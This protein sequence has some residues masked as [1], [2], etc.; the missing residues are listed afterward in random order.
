MPWREIRMSEQKVRLVLR[1]LEEGYSIAEACRIHGISRPTAY[2]WL[3]RYRAKGIR[4]LEEKSRKSLSQHPEA[5]STSLLCE[6]IKIRKEHPHWGGRT[7]RSF[8]RNRKFSKKLPHSRTIDRMLKRAG[9]VIPRAKQNRIELP[10]SRLVHPSDPNMVWTTD[11]KGWWEMLNGEKCY[12][13][14]IR[15]AMS[16]YLISFDALAQQSFELTKAAFIKAFRTYGI[17]L[18]ICSDNGQP[19]ATVQN[20]WGLTQLSVW[21]LKLGITPVRIQPGKPYQ[22]GAHERVHL[23]IAREIEKYPE[24]NLKSEQQR[25]DR[26]K[27]DFN[28]VRPHH[29]LNM[30]TPEDM[31]VASRRRYDE[32]D[33]IYMYPDHFETRS[34]SPAGQF[35]WGDK[36][37]NFSTAFRG[38]SIAIEPVDRSSVRVWFTDFCLGTCD[39]DFNNK[40]TPSKL[41][42]RV[43]IKGL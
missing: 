15:D 10:E 35:C 38:E 32:R 36:T 28:S 7:I 31:Y 29:A 2:K 22:N 37:V 1:V 18:Y 24:K 43:K 41:L 3:K 23:D 12:P 33:P 25:F 11:F 6:I 40:I 26:W 13:L 39:R 5:V 21:W 30:R 8:M 42:R 4:G 17:P 9:F 20:P 34:V 27:Y 14:T 19:F 16:R